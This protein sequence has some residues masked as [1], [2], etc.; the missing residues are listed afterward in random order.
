MCLLQ[1]LLSLH[2]HSTAAV[3]TFSLTGDIYSMLV[4]VVTWLW[5]LDPGLAA[6][7]DERFWLGIDRPWIYR[8][9]TLQT[10]WRHTF[11]QRCMNEHLDQ[12]ISRGKVCTPW[13]LSGVFILIGFNKFLHHTYTKWAHCTALLRSL[14]AGIKSSFWDSLSWYSCILF[15]HTYVSVL[16]FPS[17]SSFTSVLSSYLLISTCLDVSFPPVFLSP[18]VPPI[19]LPSFFLQCE[20]SSPF[21]VLH[22]FYHTN[23]QLLNHPD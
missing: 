3:C 9:A 17:P 11:A 18:T 16:F 5:W 10:R 2:H 20:P 6:V 8:I 12:H 19:V 22:S 14:K 1:F 15:Q 7:T 13:K 4:T 21:I 23:R